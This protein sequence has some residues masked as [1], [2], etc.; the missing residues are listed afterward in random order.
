LAVKVVCRNLFF[1]E[2]GHVYKEKGEVSQ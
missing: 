1:K 2:Y